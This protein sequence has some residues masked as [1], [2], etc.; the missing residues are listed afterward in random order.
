M[1]MILV[2]VGVS[3]VVEM[4][5]LPH[6]SSLSSLS[7]PLLSSSVHH[8]HLLLL[9]VVVVRVVHG[10]TGGGDTC[11]CTGVWYRGT[12]VLD[13]GTVHSCHSTVAPMITV[14]VVVVVE[15]HHHCHYHIHHSSSSP[16]CYR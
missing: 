5:Y 14:V 7:S 13:T 8:Y 12:V 2:R 1:M 6:G 16:S 9:V 3:T 4:S 10:D 11:E 15:H